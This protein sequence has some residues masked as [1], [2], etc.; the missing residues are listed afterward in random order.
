M[1]MRTITKSIVVA[2]VGE[3]V[4]KCVEKIIFENL[5]LYKAAAAHSM[6]V[7]RQIAKWR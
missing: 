7:R 1:E 4:A 6:R 3:K 5:V 2:E